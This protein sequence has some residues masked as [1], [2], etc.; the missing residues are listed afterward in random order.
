MTFLVPYDGSELAKA[1]LVRADEYA[2]ALDEDVTVVA[3][4]P[5]GKRY[6]REKGW[7]G[8]GEAFEVREVVRDLHREVTDLSP[9]ASFRS[10]R[11]DGS[12]TAGTVANAI[13]RVARDVD[14]G[15][16]FLGS[17]DAGRIVVP[18]SSVGGSVAS[19]AGYDVHIVRRREPPKV[20]SMRYRSEFYPTE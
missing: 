9:E 3:V 12:A 17:E 4:V 6:A 18:V 19:D 16:V 20:E 14:A 7:I 2:A 5:E 11:V 15:V 10:T 1:A 13:R 8:P